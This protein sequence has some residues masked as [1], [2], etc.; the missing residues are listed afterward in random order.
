MGL[1]HDKV[2]IDNIHR[3]SDT[4][5]CITCFFDFL[6]PFGGDYYYFFFFLI[7]QLLILLLDYSEFLEYAY[8]SKQTA[9]SKV[10]MC[11]GALQNNWSV[12]FLDKSCRPQYKHSIF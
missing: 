11:T 1:V 4:Q 9:P 7:F 6:V 8:S 12:K 2:I 10:H 3:I 5:S